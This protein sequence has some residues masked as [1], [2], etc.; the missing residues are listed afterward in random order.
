MRVHE[1]ETTGSRIIPVH[2]ITLVPTPQVA[3]PASYAVV[4]L[5]PVGCTPDGETVVIA[6]DGYNHTRVVI[7]SR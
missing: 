5:T 7:R 4:D 2:P 6:R 3:P 1:I